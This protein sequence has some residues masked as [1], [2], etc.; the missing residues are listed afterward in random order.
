MVTKRSDCRDLLSFSEQVK[1]EYQVHENGNQFGKISTKLGHHKNDFLAAH[2]RLTSQNNLEQ[3]T[4]LD[5]LL[6]M[7]LANPRALISWLQ[8]AY[9]YE[10]F[11]GNSPFISAKK[12]SI[13]SQK[14][15]I[16]ESFNDFFND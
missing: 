9:K 7:T 4:G 3:Y 1:R 5:N 2:L 10:V 16:R 14:M 8:F 11:S 12:I 15:A 6:V 13:A